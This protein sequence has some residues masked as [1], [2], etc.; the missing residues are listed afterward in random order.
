[1]RNRRKTRR[2]NN[3]IKEIM[4][5]K[6]FKSTIVLLVGLIVVLASVLTIRKVSDER[7]IAKQRLAL[8]AQ[9]EEI[10]SAGDD[11]VSKKMKKKEIDENGNEV[12]VEEEI[13]TVKLSAVGDILCNTGILN[14]GYSNG[15]YSFYQMFLP[16]IEFVSGADITLGTLETNFVDGEE[17]VGVGK[18]NSPM[19]FLKS[20]KSSGINLVSLSHNHVLDY[21]KEGLMETMAKVK[22]NGMDVTGINY[23]TNDDFTGIIKEVNNI[24]IS[25]L[26]YTYGLSNEEGLTD[27]E[28]KMANIYSDEL[29]RKEIEY[30]RKNSDY[31]III[32]HW[33]DVNV[34]KVTDSQRVI[35]DNLF[36]YGADMILG[37]HP[38]VVETMEIRKNKDGKDVFVAYSLGNYISSLTYEDA[39]VELILNME[40]AKTK[41]MDHAELQSVDY[42]PIYV[43]DRGA[44][45][46]DRYV[47]QDMKKLAKDYADGN[48][49]TISRATYDSII[50][51]LD[52][53]N[54][55]LIK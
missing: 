19:D 41:D 15:S 39:N 37:S 50:S 48:R 51:K 14:D 13:Y 10:F 6:R 11:A 47:L 18:Y 45:A 35:A 12:E 8:E 2:N 53:L 21:K 7:L 54:S 55:L 38:A 36:N 30:A 5:T 24:K 52:K 29:A 25:F 42:T 34:S 22:N 49:D 3:K 17:F 46:Q 44:N 26:G 23:G 4:E 28:K 16:I 31:V 33:G 9:T 20:V 43:L 1:M 32:M 40:I 27:E